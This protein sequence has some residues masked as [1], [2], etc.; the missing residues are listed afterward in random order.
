M[1]P[2]LYIETWRGL[3]LGISFPQVSYALVKP[4]VVALLTQF[5]LR[6]G[7]FKEIRGFWVCSR[8]LLLFS[9][10]WKLNNFPLTFI[11]TMWWGY[12]R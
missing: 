3:D 4:K 2:F 9:S 1:G 10:R 6:E 11:V 8:W 5:P 7:F 12:W